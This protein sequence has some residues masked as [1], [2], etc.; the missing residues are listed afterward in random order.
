[1]QN[2]PQQELPFS[3]FCRYM[4]APLILVK[5]VPRQQLIPLAVIPV[6]H[7]EII[8]R[9]CGRALNSGTGACEYSCTE[10]QRQ[11]QTE[12]LL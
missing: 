8:V 9:D 12:A 3:V 11:E 6:S 10:M 1:V 7:P 4:G 2:A 5:N